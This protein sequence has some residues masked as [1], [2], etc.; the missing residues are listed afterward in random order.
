[1]FH[2][3]LAAVFLTVMTTSSAT[4]PPSEGKPLR[5]AKAFLRGDVNDDGMR[6]VMDV[7]LLV[8]YIMTGQGDFD[9]ALGD[10][11]GSGTIS[12]SDI[13]ILV[14]IILGGDYNDP[15]N[16]SLPLDDIGGGDPADGL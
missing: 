14:N 4:L 16:P 7:T 9:T 10:L 13:S 3:L 2:T 8:D 11:D 1:M 6:T 5:A 12:V 15:D